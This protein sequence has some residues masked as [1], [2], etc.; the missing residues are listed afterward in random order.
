MWRARQLDHYARTEMKSKCSI[1]FRNS[2]GF[3][4]IELL[5][6][7]AIIAILASL[8]LP[9]LGGAKLRAQGV[10]CM[11]NEKQMINATMMYNTD[12]TEYFP[13]NPDDGNDVPGYDWCAGNVSGG[14]PPGS[15]GAPELY[16]TEIL[17][18]PIRNLV[19]VYLGASHGVWKCP[20][21]PRF[22][23]YVSCVD[24]DPSRL[25]T[26][27]AAA[28]SIS[29]NQGVGTVDPL[30]AA[31]WFGHSGKPIL[32][33]N[34]PW[35]DGYHGHIHNKPYATFG[36]TSDFG[37]TSPSLIFWTV[38]EDPY[39]INDAALAVSAAVPEIVDSPASFHANA[40]GLSFCDGHAEI[41]KWLSSVMKP[42][43]QVMVF[44]GGSIKPAP[45]PEYQDWYWLASHATINT[46]TNTIP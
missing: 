17:K 35:L 6:V 21:D 24:Q 11:N 46:L 10:Y 26:T 27:V 19:S 44:G 15:P 39:S 12:N 33:V 9:A 40:C 32:P 22:G 14:T 4:L 18:D 13:P 36:K 42:S 1:L 29:G 7:I 30:F 38:D 28:R 41:H 25:G 43:A 37:L 3:T 31:T 45:S 2:P 23:K 8:L 34:G 16:D 20:A 5:V